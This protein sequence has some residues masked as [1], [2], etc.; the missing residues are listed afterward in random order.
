MLI[1]SETE[2]RTRVFSQRVLPI[3]RTAE[4][5]RLRRPPTRGRRRSGR[6]TNHGGGPRLDPRPTVAGARRRAQAVGR[7]GGGGRSRQGGVRNLYLSQ[8]LVG[9]RE[10][11][12]ELVR[13]LLVS[14]P[15]CPLLTH[16][17]L[18]RPLPLHLL[19]FHRLLQSHTL[20]RPAKRRRRRRR[21][22]GTNVCQLEFLVKVGLA[23]LLTNATRVSLHWLQLECKVSH[24]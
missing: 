10:G 9:G 22:K 2:P 24:D 20:T 1:P 7:R 3:Y 8:V 15:L 21:R 17:R 6:R 14:L 13:L 19:L 12:V 18:V 23:L 4:S 11:D 16:R 5:R